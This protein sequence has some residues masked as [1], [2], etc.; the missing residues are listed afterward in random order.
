MLYE[1]FR[2]MLGAW[3]RAVVDWL[4]AHPATTAL[5]LSIWLSLFFAGKYQLH[6]LQV[7]T[8][9]WAIE[10]ATAVLKQHPGIT[11]QQL[12]DQL[13]PDWRQM[14][15]RTAWFIPHRWELWPLPATPD[16]AAKRIDF[17]PQWLRNHL[18]ENGIEIPG[19]A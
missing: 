9:V 1:I 19:E 3:S 12:Y 18:M 17:T 14:L 15:R 11:A 6:R 13:Y 7:R 2:S 5:A 10:N 8:Q 4:Q 16:R